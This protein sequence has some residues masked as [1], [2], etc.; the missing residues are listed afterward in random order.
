MFAACSLPFLI[1]QKFVIE[2]N[3]NL[4]ISIGDSIIFLEV[5]S[6]SEI[7]ERLD[8]VYIDFS[9]SIVILKN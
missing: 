2:K 6:R 9:P 8:V 4:A 7:K 5:E 3:G 1:F